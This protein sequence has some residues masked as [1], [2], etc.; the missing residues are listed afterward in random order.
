[1]CAMCALAAM[2]GASGTRVW[3]QARHETWLTPR[4]MQV[5]T[6]GLFATATLG[7]S[8]AFSGS[9]APTSQPTRGPQQHLAGER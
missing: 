9:S 5:V 2:T 7:S 4:R 3:L 8:V 1:M 6:V